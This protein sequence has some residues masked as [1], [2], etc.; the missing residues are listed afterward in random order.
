MQPASRF[1]SSGPV[2]AIRATAGYAAAHPAKAI[3]ADDSSADALLWAHPGLA[4]RVGFDDRLEIYPRAAVR[5]WANFIRGNRSTLP[6]S[7]GILVAGAGNRRLMRRIRP[8]S[9]WRVIY[10]RS[11][12]IA[13]VRGA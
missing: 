7:Y 9:D 1:G 12:G 8:L 10:D 2:G 5:R 13:A 6:G 11:D 3:L 4:G